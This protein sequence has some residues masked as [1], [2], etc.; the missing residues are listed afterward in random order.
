MGTPEFEEA[1]GTISD[2]MEKNSEAFADMSQEEAEAIIEKVLESPEEANEIA[3]ELLKEYDEKNKDKEKEAQ[4]LEKEEIADAFA[5]Q[6]GGKPSS[7]QQAL[8]DLISRGLKVNLKNGKVSSNEDYQ[9]NAKKEM[10]E[11]ID[12]LKKESQKNTKSSEVKKKFLKAIEGKEELLIN[13]LSLLVKLAIGFN[14]E[15]NEKEEL[16]YEKLANTFEFLMKYKY[17]TKMPPGQDGGKGVQIDKLVP[18]QK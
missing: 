18:R 6:K 17:T 11:Y 8:G 10:Q 16:D 4:E 1:M 5:N 2:L 12:I 13:E 15:K 7:P 3:K 9:A 14:N